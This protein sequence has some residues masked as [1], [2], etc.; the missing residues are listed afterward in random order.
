MTLTAKGSRWFFWLATLSCYRHT[1]DFQRSPLNPS[2]PADLQTRPQMFHFV[3]WNKLMPSNFHLRLVTDGGNEWKTS[4]RRVED[5]GSKTIFMENT[6][7]RSRKV[8]LGILSSEC[9][10]PKSSLH[11]QRRYYRSSA[12]LS[13]AV[14]K[15]RINSKKGQEH[16]FF[17]DVSVQNVSKPVQMFQILN[18]RLNL[19]NGT[20]AMEENFPNK[21]SWFL[22]ILPRVEVYLPRVWLVNRKPCISQLETCPFI[23]AGHA[24]AHSGC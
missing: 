11:E 7:L 21:K 14:F 9:G 8:Q 3:D 6:L 24:C 18:C 19:T 20:V 15:Q 5:A 10:V 1:G 12:L 13:H 2:R 17:F 23:K 22:A 16:F 4:G